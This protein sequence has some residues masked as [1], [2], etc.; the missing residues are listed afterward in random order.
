[1][2]ENTDTLRTVLYA[3]LVNVV[4]AVVKLTAGLLSGSAAMLAEA[5][6]SGVDCTT[7]LLLAAGERHALRRAGVQYRYA[8]VAAL[9]MLLS[10]GLYGLYGGVRA[11]LGHASHEGAAV[12]ALIVLALASSLEATSCCRAVRQLAATRNGRGWFAHLRTTEDTASKTI[13]IEDGADIAGNMIAAI[14]IALSALTG[15]SWLDAAASILVGL[16][17]VA[18]SAELGSHNVRL[19]RAAHPTTEL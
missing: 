17:L 7:Q 15:A 16:L 2:S 11:L 13:V 19:I 9:V 18:L 14:G 5:A 12:L 4:V 6:H 8:L 3:L 10:G 1:M